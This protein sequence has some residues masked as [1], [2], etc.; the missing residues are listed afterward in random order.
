MCL[1]PVLIRSLQHRKTEEMRVC[2][3]SPATDEIKHFT[4]SCRYFH[5][6][7]THHWSSSLLFFLQL[8]TENIICRC[9]S[10]L[11]AP[12]ASHYMTLSFSP[13]PIKSHSQLSW[14]TCEKWNHML[15]LKTQLWRRPTSRVP[16]PSVDRIGEIA[17]T[18]KTSSA[19]ETRRAK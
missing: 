14:A 17:D 3:K 1:F 8:G 13:R 11:K 7:S 12:Q 2:H 6:A 18:N 5:R 16:R 15:S 19:E 10:E 9:F 4:K